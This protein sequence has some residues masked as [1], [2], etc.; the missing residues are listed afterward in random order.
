MI[1]GMLGEFISTFFLILIGIGGCIFVSDLTRL[2]VAFIWG[3]A[4]FIGSLFGNLF[5]SSKMNP[6]FLIVDL[7]TTESTISILFFKLFGEI[8]GAVLATMILLKKTK[9]RRTNLTNYAAIA[10]ISSKSI[11]FF[12]EMC[13]TLSMILMSSIVE[14][15][16]S[17]L[18]SIFLMSFYIGVLIFGLA[19]ITGAS[20]NPV[21]DFI[22]RCVFSFHKQDRGNFKNSILSSNVAPLISSLLWISLHL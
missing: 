2:K 20:F 12:I 15:F 13:A 5:G 16:S 8:L 11:A 7:A 6:V 22:P 1:Y 21:R 9:N 17:Q 4:V 18:F 3:M 10:S 19:P 14:G